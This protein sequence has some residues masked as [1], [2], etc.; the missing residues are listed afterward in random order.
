MLKKQRIST[1]L[2]F[3]IIII[4]LSVNCK[5][6]EYRDLV[7]NYIGV[8]DVF[9]IKKNGFDDSWNLIEETE[10][11]DL[12]VEKTI[13]GIRIKDVVSFENFEV[14]YSDSTFRAS[15]SDNIQSAYGKFLQNDS[16]Y[17]QVS[18]SHKLPFAYYYH[19]KKK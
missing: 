7:N 12:E 2:F 6:K 19:M 17:I 4:F 8:Y 1:K 10:E 15:D 13:R 18:L 9:L 5:K 16:I 3:F 11:I 14:D